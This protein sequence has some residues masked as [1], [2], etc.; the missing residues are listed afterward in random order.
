[1][2]SQRWNTLQ[3]NVVK[4]I[5][6]ARKWVLSVATWVLLARVRNSF[7]SK[8]LSGLSISALILSNIPDALTVLG[9]TP[10]TIVSIYFGSVVFLSGYLLFYFYSPNEF[11]GQGEMVDHIS[12]MQVLSSKKFVASRMELAQ[13]FIERVSAEDDFE[14][15]SGVLESLKETVVYFREKKP[16][17]QLSEA[18]RLYQDDLAAREHDFPSKRL[19]VSLLLSAGAILIALP[20]I[21]NVLVSLWS[22]VF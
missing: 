16:A 3:T 19:R 20:T 12:R 8:A 7:A 9:V 21:I 22:V 11:K 13:T 15:P 5:A 4:S 18:S 10:W 2:L 1:M 17:K 14:I 6:S